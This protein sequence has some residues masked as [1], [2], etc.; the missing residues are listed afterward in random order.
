MTCQLRQ[1]AKLNREFA[2]KTLER[3]ADLIAERGRHVATEGKA[4]GCGLIAAIM[5]GRSEIRAAETD[6]NERD[7]TYGYV[8]L[9]HDLNDY[10]V[11]RK[12]WTKDAISPITYWGAHPD[13]GP[14]E[15]AAML[16]EAAGDI[17]RRA[18]DRTMAGHYHGRYVTDPHEILK[19]LTARIKQ[20][21]P[22]DE[23]TDTAHHIAKATGANLVGLAYR[24]AR[25]DAEMDVAP[26]DEFEE[27]VSLD[28]ALMAF[29]ALDH[30]HARV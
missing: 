22:D 6:A 8:H 20:I 13:I 5:Q 30:Y 23:P 15:A 21:N 24:G 10:I 29:E 26:R 1:S 19:M 12:V 17:G 16:R 3:A 18:F 28:P 14:A 2:Q 7:R 9:I 25:I 4:A 11:H 27:E